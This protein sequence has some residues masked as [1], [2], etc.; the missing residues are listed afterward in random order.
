M[1]IRTTRRLPSIPTHRTQR[2]SYGV[3]Q[4]QTK[5]PDEIIERLEAVKWTEAGQDPDQKIQTVPFALSP[6]KGYELSQMAATTLF[7]LPHVLQLAA[8]R[9]LS[10]WF[11]YT[12][13][14]PTAI[15]EVAF[16]PVLLPVWMVD[17]VVK[18]KA[19]LG[20]TQVDLDVSST[21]SP[22]PG[23]HLPPLSQLNVSPPLN[24]SDLVPFSP[25]EHLTQN[26]QTVTLIPFTR[27]PLNLLKKLSSLPRR[28]ARD[29]DDV[30]FDP[31]QFKETMFAAY[32]LYV[33]LYLGEWALVEGD[34][35]K[36]V[37]TAAF[38][39]TDSPAFAIYPSFRASESPEPVTWL[40]DADSLSLTI[41]GRP[42]HSAAAVAQ[43]PETIS[44]MKELS[45]RL[46][47]V[48]D[49][50]K[51]ERNA[52]A[53]E[54]GALGDLWAEVT[55]VI[56]G[57]EEAVKELCRNEDRVMAYGVW[58]EINTAYIE[59]LSGLELAQ[60]NLEALREL[61]AF[62]GLVITPTGVR[63]STLEEMVTELE[64]AV[65]QWKDLLDEHTPE[66]IR[67]VEARRKGIASGGG[68]A[69]RLPRERP[70][71]TGSNKA[72]K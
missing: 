63:R 30:S 53:R 67:R 37:T 47:R 22:I 19:L 64:S 26:G 69:G 12:A 21:A 2:R 6:D 55:E 15:R 61:P 35:E 28:I 60:A 32:P 25:S 59:A 17:I 68:G 70:A 71:T 5:L 48:I 7:G 34:Q 38:A 45:P 54:S 11:G 49:E 3:S 46:L 9:I 20:D 41:S 18:G 16:S 52:R 62:S 57:G 58:H 42:S 10:S 31:K 65:S 27:H 40:P 44:S 8:H 29:D 24:N 36:R 4:L 14:K 23:F 56:Q 43:D 39:G 66:W 51:E 50:I 1:I 13:L 72:Q 33:P